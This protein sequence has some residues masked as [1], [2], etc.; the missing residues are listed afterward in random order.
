MLFY[1]CNADEQDMSSD[2][3]TVQCNVYRGAL[4][5]LNENNSLCSMGDLTQ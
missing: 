2:F 1:G 5:L 4:S 3:L